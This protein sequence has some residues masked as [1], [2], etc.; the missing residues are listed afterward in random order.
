M[1]EPSRS[2]AHVYGSLPFSD[3]VLDEKEQQVA[4]LMNQDELM[5]NHPIKKAMILT[6]ISKEKIRESAWYE[7]SAVRNGEKTDV[8]LRAYRI[9][10][11]MLYG[12]K[13]VMRLKRK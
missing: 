6:G 5:T 13:E 7:G 9:Y 3:D 1:G 8:H 4:A 12:K 2:E 10:K 11:W